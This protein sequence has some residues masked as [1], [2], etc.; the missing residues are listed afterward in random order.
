M[1]RLIPILV[2]G[3]FFS[4]ERPADYRVILVA[5]GSLRGDFQVDP[6]GRSGL[7]ALHTYVERLRSNVRPEAGRVLLFHAGNLT[8]AFDSQEFRQKIMSPQWS[9]L[10]RPA[11]DVLALSSTELLFIEE[12]AAS[13][14]E[15][16]RIYRRTLERLPVVAFDYACPREK[17]IIS[18]Y[19][20]LSARS[21]NADYDPDN[22]FIFTS[23]LSDGV[24]PCFVPAPYA[25]LRR[26]LDEQSGSSLGVFLLEAAPAVPVARRDPASVSSELSEAL[27]QERIL[28]H[29]QEESFGPDFD[30]FRPA[31]NPYTALPVKNI[32]IVAIEAGAA[33]NRF[34]QLPGGLRVCRLM[35]RHV[36][37][38][39]LTFRRGRLIVFKQQF[40]DLNGLQRAHGWIPPDRILM[41][42]MDSDREEGKGQA[43]D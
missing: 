27:D 36:C 26:E 39:D 1:R 31:E 19:R 16:A 28:S 2:C 13:D 35:G 3:V 18:P 5:V 38:L 8:G 12:Q 43:T 17:R 32:P 21:L 23:S 37:V 33:E 40:V 9:I 14:H 41:E 30:R 20:I 6:A 10:E 42:N 15:E 34:F 22:I 7:A 24:G 11:F 29:V 25:A 4:Y